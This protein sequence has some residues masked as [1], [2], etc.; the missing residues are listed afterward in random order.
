MKVDL[1]KIKKEIARLPKAADYKP[2]AEAKAKLEELRREL[3]A[4]RAQV[5]ALEVKLD[6]VA[7]KAELGEISKK[8]LEQTEDELDRAKRRVRALEGAMRELNTQVKAEEKNMQMFILKAAMELHRPLIEAY[9]E[10]WK[11]AE[12]IAEVED[13]ITSHVQRETHVTQG[14][15]FP[16]FFVLHRRKPVIWLENAKKGGYLQ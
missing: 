4:A 9:Y 8:Q 5:E 7:K 16:V 6:E 10:V 12:A 11:Q 13:I 2:Y 14:H 1:E 15:E 3:P